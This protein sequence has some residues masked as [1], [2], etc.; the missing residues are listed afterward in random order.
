MRPLRLFIVFIVLL[1]SV[2]CHLFSPRTQQNPPVKNINIDRQI[3]PANQPSSVIETV[4]LMNNA[5]QNLFSQAQ[6]YY[7]NNDF[8]TAISL[9]ERAYEIQPLSPQ[10]SQFLAEIYLHKGDFDQAHYWATVATK[11]GP[12]KGKTCE[13]SWRILALAA[14][15][16]GYYAQQ[17]KALNNKDQCVV[18]APD[19]F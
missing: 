6:K 12:S 19:R 16:L 17:D 3:N 8:D 10:V 9:L 18:R 11:N 14:G 7:D 2:S 15:Q 4:P 13:K 5:T 1:F